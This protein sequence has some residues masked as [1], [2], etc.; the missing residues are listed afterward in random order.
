M[1]IRTLRRERAWTQE[2]LAL[3]LGVNVRTV[4]RL[5]N[6]GA[7]SLETAQALAS[8]FGRDARL[9]LAPGATEVAEVAELAPAAPRPEREAPPALA[10]VRSAAAFLL[11]GAALASILL[12]A[13]LIAGPASPAMV[14]VLAGAAASVG[15]G[16]GPALRRGRAGRTLRARSG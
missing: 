7:P 9:F 6:G 13:V 14:A 11:V 2:Q 12:L 8:A 10:D 3:I 1:L 15:L 4:Q 5:E 16:L